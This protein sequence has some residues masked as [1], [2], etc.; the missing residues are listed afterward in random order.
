MYINGPIEADIWMS[1]T[2]SDAGLSVR[3]DDVDS[4]GNAVA[5]TNGIQTA[6][7]RAVDTTRSRTLDGLMITPWHPYTAASVQSVGS[8]NAVRVAVEIFPTSAMIAQ[9]HSLRIAVGASDLPQGIPP[10]PTLLASLL[11]TL[12]VYS[13][14]AYPSTVVIPVVPVSALNGD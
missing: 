7:L 9:G 6:S 10:L 11:G 5:L 2:A 13:E 14:A 12:T 4:S 1:T 3:V 8:G